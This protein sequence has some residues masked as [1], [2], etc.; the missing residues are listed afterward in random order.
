M[1]TKNMTTP[2]KPLGWRTIALKEVTELRERR[3]TTS[4]SKQPTRSEI[5]EQT[6]L[7]LSQGGVIE[8]LP[9]GSA[10]HTLEWQT[11][12][13]DIVDLSRNAEG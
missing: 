13:N 8:K 5:E 9:P 11:I 3:K 7:F 1:V 12:V 6:K 10:H 4:R 2:S